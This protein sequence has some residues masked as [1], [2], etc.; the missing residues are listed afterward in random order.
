MNIGLEA[1][2]DPGWLAGLQYVRNI[3]YTIA[4]LPDDEQPTVRLLPVNAETV[5]KIADLG[6]YGFI[7][8]AAPVEATPRALEARLLARRGVRKFLQPRTGR[9]LLSPFRGLD[10]TYPGWGTRLPGTAQM[11]W[12]PDLQHVFL[13]EFFS[14]EE[15]ERRD[16]ELE[17]R[18]SGEDHLIFSS[19]SAL[20]D[21]RGVFPQTAVPTHVWQ[22]CSPVTEENLRGADPHEKYGLPSRYLY[23][24]N[25]FWAHKD[26]LTLFRA[27]VLLRE[28]GLRP[29]VVCTGL[30][31]D[32]RNPRYI[33]EL[34]AFLEREGLGDQVTILGVVPRADQVSILKHSTLVVQPSKFEGWSTVVEDAKAVG[35]P[36]VL[37]DFRVH[38]EQA[39]DHVFFEM[40]SAESL[41]EALAKH[42]PDLPDGPDPVAERDAKEVLDARRREL[43][44]SFIAICR[45]AQRDG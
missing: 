18:A 24:A 16:R 39:P 25:Q 17:E 28:S 37:S 44:R 9:A 13:P 3:V 26:H 33:A 19:H 15:I 38:L 43:A 27:L 42:L 11:H 1:G 14:S 40:G 35:R 6:R 23:V 21:F 12:V 36:M 22:F 32:R 34:E 5:A 10:V 20:A 8:I 4:S 30:L 45:E 41:A 29:T 2:F 31:A 7:E